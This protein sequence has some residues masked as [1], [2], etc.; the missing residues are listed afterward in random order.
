M[1]ELH[2]FLVLAVVSLGLAATP[3]PNMA[4]LLSRS[5]AQGPRAGLISLAGTTSATV[6]VMIAAS[7]GLAAAVLALPHLWDTIRLL[8]AG[9][10]FYLAWGMLK[11]GGKAMIEARDLP[12][13]PPA[14]LFGIGFATQVLNPKVAM[15][16]IAGLPHLIDPALGHPLRQ[17]ILLGL[18]QIGVCAAFDLAMVLG[19]G[20]VARL[21][22]GRPG[23]ILAQR[24]ATGFALG[25]VAIALLLDSAA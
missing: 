11:P 14:R 10:L 13:D 5:L 4:Y 24:W 21:F 15:F 20:A 8:G 19:A 9:Y 23:L 1:P 3:G 17:G 7:A 18:F 25:A 6:L 22:T 16:Y 12:L 2:T